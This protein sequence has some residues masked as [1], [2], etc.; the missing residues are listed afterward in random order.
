[1]YLARSV[2]GGSRDQ[3]RSAFRKVAEIDEQV[4]GNGG[5]VEFQLKGDANCYSVGLPV[6]NVCGLADG[7]V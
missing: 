7:D 6:A 3:P 1:V 5:S 2:G 4:A